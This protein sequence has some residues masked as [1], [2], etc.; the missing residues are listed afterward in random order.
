MCMFTNIKKVNLTNPSSIFMQR[1][2]IFIGKSKDYQM[3]D[4]LE[5]GDSSDFDGNTI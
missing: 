2:K 1:K 3:K 5:A 4:F